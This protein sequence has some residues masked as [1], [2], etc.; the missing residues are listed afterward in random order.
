MEISNNYTGYP[1]GMVQS[2]NYKTSSSEWTASEDRQSAYSQISD[3]VLVEI[4]E[5]GFQ[6]L[7]FDKFNYPDTE[8]AKRLAEEQAAKAA[9]WEA[10]GAVVQHAARQI[11]PNIQTNDQLVNS[12]AGLDESI[13]DAAYDIINDHLL[14]RDVSGLTE[15]QRQGLISLGMEKARYLAGN[16]EEDTAKQFL[17]AMDKIA[18][19]GMNGTAAED[20]KVTFDIKRGPLVGAPDDNAV[21]YAALMKRLDPDKY[22]EYTGLIQEGINNKD[23]SAIR[24]AVERF[25]GWS[26]DLYKNNPKAVDDAVK[27]YA[28]WKKSSEKTGISDAYKDSDYSDI[29]NFT[30]SIRS[31]NASNQLFSSDYLESMLQS[32]IK[33]LSISR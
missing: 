30:D 19:Y 20:G 10:S 9:E 15:E 23:N 29:I 16:M 8:W 18:R 22:N 28:D 11:I 13:V 2:L 32:F 24:K 6:R 3:S 25:I 31:Q 27:D 14:K 1:A 12:L 5:E 7:K 4:S 17:Q 26:I 33:R 21:D